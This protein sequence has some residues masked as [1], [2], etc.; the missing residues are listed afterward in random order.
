MPIQRTGESAQSTHA[1][2]TS[3]GAA[4]GLGP[5]FRRAPFV[6]PACGS[7]CIGREEGSGR[8]AGADGQGAGAD[9]QGRP[10][11]EAV[12]FDGEG[13]RRGRFGGLVAGF[14]GEQG[15]TDQV[16]VRRVGCS[17]AR[18]AVV[19]EPTYRRATERARSFCRAPGLRRS[20]CCTA[21]LRRRGEA[22][23]TAASPQRR[24]R[25]RPA[26]ARRP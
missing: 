1:F 17:K 15:H 25:Q 10:Q 7:E 26:A 4:L 22:T 3:S 16:G 6:D 2:L 14:V 20:G 11:E 23:H 21:G 5:W 18:R 8:E 24:Q 13:F 19:G 9:G 12:R